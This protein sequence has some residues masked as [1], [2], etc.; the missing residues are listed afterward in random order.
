MEI[1]KDENMV[2]FKAQH[3]PMPEYLHVLMQTSTFLVDGFHGIMDLG[4]VGSCGATFLEDLR[5][6]VLVEQHHSYLTA[7]DLI[8]R[9]I[10]I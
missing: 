8:L 4:M 10:Q 9:V 6:L 5:V 1:L 7:I 3:P 2:I